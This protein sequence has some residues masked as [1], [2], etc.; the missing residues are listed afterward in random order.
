MLRRAQRLPP[1]FTRKSPIDAATMKIFNRLSD[2][3]AGKRSSG[4][5][6]GDTANLLPSPS[7]TASSPDPLHASLPYGFEWS[8]RPF[9]HGQTWMLSLSTTA[10]SRDYQQAARLTLLDKYVALSF[11]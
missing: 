3:F 1:S 8:P 10:I 4:Q 11:P 6:S 9:T 7:N 2:K 5:S